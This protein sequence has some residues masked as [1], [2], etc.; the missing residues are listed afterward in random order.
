MKINMPKMFKKYSLIIILLILS[1]VI[2]YR[3]ITFNIFANGDYGYFT[4]ITVKNLAMDFSWISIWNLGSINF[5][6]WRFVLV[7]AQ[8]LFANLGYSF[9]IS[10]KFLVFWPTLIV[11][12]ISLF[13]LVKKISKSDIAAFIGAIIF[14]YNTYYIVNGDAFYLYSSAAWVLLSFYL[15]INALESQKKYLFLISGLL[16]FVAGSYDFR[17]AYIGAFVLFIYSLY[18]L[19]FIKNLKISIEFF[20]ELIFSLI[21]FFIFGFLN[22]YWV[23]PMLKLGSLTSNA[24]LDRGLF[25]NEFLNILYSITI[26]HPFWTG[27]K[28]AWF[29]VE[30]IMAY[31]WLIPILAFLG[32]YLNR[33]NK[34]ILFFGIIALLG[35]FLT[36]QVAI[37]FTGIY[38]WLF[39]HLLGFNAFREASKF[40]FL[41]AL[42]YSVLIGA[43]VKY[44]FENI[45]NAKVYLK[46]ILVIIIALLFLWNVKP[47]L[48]GE[49]SGIYVSRNIPRDYKILND[50][51][52][53]NESYSRIFLVPSDSTWILYSVNHPKAILS[54]LSSV[55]KYW[56]DAQNELHVGKYSAGEI[57]IKLFKLPLSNNL[58]DESSIQYVFVPTEDAANDANNFV[59]YGEPRQY[60]INQLSE[61]TWLKKVDI[62]TKNLVVYE[63]E[64]YRPHI[65]ITNNQETINK[66]QL[67]KTVTFQFINPSEYQVQIENVKGP[68]Y[69]NFSDSFNPQWRL[70]IGSFNWL[71]VV[72]R[73]DYFIP[74][75]YHFQNDANLNSYFL[76]PESIC[77]QFVCKLNQDGTYDINMALYFVPQSYMYLGLII[78]GGTLALVLGYLGL[79]FGRNIYAKKHN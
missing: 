46:C 51:I 33:K 22:I 20:K 47:I 19:L 73:K 37:P 16:L 71:N 44:L 9:N 64:N 67:Y 14:N 60:Y 2:Y 52:T 18:Y 76:D 7:F 24:V 29:I 42:G 78:S 5:T 21:P 40:Y 1:V 25:G 28:S 48:T 58:L 11:A 34:N 35:V 63:N 23:L 61:I 79:I 30:P 26:F 66:S 49:I 72:A 70:R 12:N 77:R 27:T 45:K 3:W 65:Y 56:V 6:I 57:V 39:T 41:I 55:Y 31:F 10:E 69:L 38:A 50:Y 4:S 62:G 68:F 59:F 74:D 13:F 36:K 53:E 8:S 75:K 15:F 32:L 43:F 54:N 17:V